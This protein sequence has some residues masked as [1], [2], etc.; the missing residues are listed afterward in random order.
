[1]GLISS[2]AAPSAPQFQSVIVKPLVR[3]MAGLTTAGQDTQAAT[4][5]VARKL[6]S[7]LPSELARR[8]ILP[9]AASEAIF[10][11]LLP[12][13]PALVQV[14]D[15]TDSSQIEILSEVDGISLVGIPYL[16][17]GAVL[18]DDLPEV[19]PVPAPIAK[20]TE[21][22]TMAVVIPAPLRP[23][24]EPQLEAEQVLSDQAERA[25]QQE[26]E[27]SALKAE[28]AA[29]KAAEAATVYRETPNEPDEKAA[30]SV[31]KRA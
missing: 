28:P 8:P 7:E 9:P 2:L 23:E 19:E 25:Y 15:A 22:D 13:Q 24:V 31:D 10:K 30:P 27:I 17:D 14:G 20:H 5:T 16:Q 12:V 18:L 26:R 1:M 4:Q 3:G 6:R 11:G 29:A 21:T